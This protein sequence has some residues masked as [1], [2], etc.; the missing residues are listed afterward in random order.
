M[1]GSSRTDGCILSSGHAGSVVSTTT[2]TTLGAH[3]W[4]VGTGGCGHERLVTR[5]DWV[6]AVWHLIAL[7][8]VV[9]A[10]FDDAPAFYIG[11]AV[12]VTLV[13]APVLLAINNRGR[14]VPV[15]VLD[16][17]MRA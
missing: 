17:G 1:T 16:R 15:S 10:A 8:F 3:G 7:T 2:P 12:L 13:R 6:Q 4:I 11:M 5:P 9:L 14:L